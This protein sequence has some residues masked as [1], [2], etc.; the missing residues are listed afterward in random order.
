MYM[1]MKKDNRLFKKLKGFQ[2]A[3]R[4]RFF[5]LALD[6]LTQEEFILHELFIAIT[7]WDTNHFETY[8]TFEA[9][10][11]ELAQILKWKADS[12]VSR[13]KKSLIDKGFVELAGERFRVKDF[14]KWQ[15]KKSFAKTQHKDAE[16]Q[17][18]N[19]KMQ[20]GLAEMHEIP[21]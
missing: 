9:T 11:K 8:G 6:Q 1:K 5:L 12:T 18:T 14:E 13:H 2:R 20:D 17:A 21:F 10:N 16:M 3:D 4:G 7:D 15:Y 19:A